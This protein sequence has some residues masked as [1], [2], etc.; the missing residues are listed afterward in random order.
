MGW[1]DEQHA[2]EAIVTRAQRGGAQSHEVLDVE[3]GRVEAG[4]KAGGGGS[5]DNRGP[6]RRQRRAA[7]VRVDPKIG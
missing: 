4:V 5:Q 2:A 6:R 3:P 1:V 7:G